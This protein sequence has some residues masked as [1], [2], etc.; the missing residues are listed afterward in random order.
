MSTPTRPYVEVRAYTDLPAAGGTLLGIVG[1]WIALS[2]TLRSDGDDRLEGTISATSPGASHLEAGVCLVVTET[3]GTVRDWLVQTVRDDLTPDTLT[4]AA[5]SARVWLAERVL[6]RSGTDVTLSGSAAL[7]DVID[8]LVA[9]DEWP[10]WAVPGTF[11]VNPTIAYSW[12]LANGLAAC[13][14]AATAADASGEVALA[15]DTVRFAFRRVSA[16]QYALDFLTSVVSGSPV[17]AQGKNI[18]SFAIRDDR[19]QQ[20]TAIYPVNTGGATIEEAMFVVRTVASNTFDVR[21]WA[22]RDDFLAIAFDDQWVGYYAVA[23]D[24]T[25]SVITSSDAALQQITV[26]DAS[27][28]GAGNNATVRFSPSAS[29]DYTLAVVDTAATGRRN[30]VLSGGTWSAKIN[31]LPNSRWDEWSSATV[32]RDWAT[33]GGLTSNRDTTVGNVE[34]G[35]YSIELVTG[36]STGE[37]TVSE[38]LM[39]DEVV[40]NNGGTQTWRVGV[41]SKMTTSTGGAIA[42]QVSKDSGATWGAASFGVVIGPAG[43]WYTTEATFTTNT[44]T[45]NNRPRVRFAQTNTVAGT[46]VIIDRVWLFRDGVEDDDNEYVGNGPSVGFYTAQRALLRARTAGRAYEIGIADRTRDNPTAFPNDALAPGM[47]AR[48]IVPARSVDVQQAVAEV[49]RDLLQPLT[50]TVQLG[51]ARRK[52]TKIV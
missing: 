30:L 29:V 51:A 14:G 52:L 26:A 17:L 19:T 1:P 4:I 10:A 5:L 37:V 46:K 25:T 8:V 48:V 40:T 23:P 42:L 35:T 3:S 44:A 7:E 50:T 34:T 15:G 33:S 45:L 36:G 32:I 43:T 38:V 11:D 2:D 47:V 9:T 6:V 13:T 16:T 41:R 12:S 49:R 18:T 39:P 22:Y 31:W 20:P 28:W 21:D 27:A 24:G